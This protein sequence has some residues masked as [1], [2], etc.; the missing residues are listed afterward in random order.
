MGLGWL[1]VMLTFANFVLLSFAFSDQL[2]VP[3]FE[4]VYTFAE[5][6][7]YLL[8]GFPVIGYLTGF[9]EA[10]ELRSDDGDSEGEDTEADEVRFEKT[11]NGYEEKDAEEVAG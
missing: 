7:V 8:F 2:T 1:A 3:Q 11:E 4:T 10:F 6:G 9:I 5:V